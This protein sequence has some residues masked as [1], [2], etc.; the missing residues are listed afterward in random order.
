M[1]FFYCGKIYGTERLDFDISYRH[2]SLNEEC[3][4]MINKMIK[5]TVLIRQLKHIVTVEILSN[6]ER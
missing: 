3:E 6:C 4:I 1:I 2:Y 5:N